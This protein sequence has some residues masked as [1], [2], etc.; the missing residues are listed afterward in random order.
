MVTMG[1]AGVAGGGGDGIL[2]G[3]CHSDGEDEGGNLHLDLVEYA[4]C[5]TVGDQAA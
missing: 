2:G 3:Y 4:R 5:K 1:L